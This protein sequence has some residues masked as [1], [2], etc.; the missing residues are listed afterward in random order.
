M[1]SYLYTLYGTPLNYIYLPHLKQRAKNDQQLQ[2]TIRRIELQNQHNSI[3]NNGRD[4]E[5]FR[6]PLALEVLFLLDANAPQ[7]H[8][9]HLPSGYTIYNLIRFIQKV[10]EGVIYTHNASITSYRSIISYDLEPKTLITVRLETDNTRKD[11]YGK[12]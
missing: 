3:L 1:T 8:A 7:R 9:N 2:L 10:S 5:P 12:E 6:G 4:V 11:D